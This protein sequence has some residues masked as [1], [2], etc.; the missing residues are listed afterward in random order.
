MPASVVLWIAIGSLSAL[1]VW[2]GRSAFLALDSKGWPTA[3][4]I[5]LSSHFSERSGE[6]GTRYVLHVTYSYPVANLTYE[7]S[8]THFGSHLSMPPFVQ[9]TKVHADVA[10]HRYRP[11]STLVVRYHPRRPSLCTIRTGAPWGL[12]A[13]I[14]VLSYILSQLSVAAFRR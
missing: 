6:S 11:G 9:H 2:L 1:L 10:L 14:L 12:Y 3:E 4:G 5:V 7:G 13:S 8:R